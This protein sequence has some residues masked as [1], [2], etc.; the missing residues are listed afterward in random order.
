MMSG[1]KARESQ[2]RMYQQLLFDED[3]FEG[4]GP[5]P[6]WAGLV[7]RHPRHRHLNRPTLLPLTP[8]AWQAIDKACP[9]YFNEGD[10]AFEQNVFEASR[11][12]F[13]T[14]L[15]LRATAFLTPTLTKASMCFWR[16]LMTSSAP[17]R[18]SAL[19]TGQRSPRTFTPGGTSCPT[20]FTS[21]TRRR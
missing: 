21:T 10:L 15:P 1:W 18:V 14:R 4:I 11:L 7:G 5:S 19:P 16:T 2:S 17:G 13:S 8:E 3:R 9:G 20:P 12:G 6:E